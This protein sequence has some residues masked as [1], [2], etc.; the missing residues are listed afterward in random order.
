M[1]SLSVKHKNYLEG[2][3]TNIGTKVRVQF[4]ISMCAKNETKI[5]F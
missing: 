5:Y 1:D 4:Y 3:K 2:D